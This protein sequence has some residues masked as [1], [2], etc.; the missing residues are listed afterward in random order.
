[1][2]DFVWKIPEMVLP[3]IGKVNLML[4]SHRVLTLIHNIL[5]PMLTALVHA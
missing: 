5:V 4:G 3:R 1:M 2:D